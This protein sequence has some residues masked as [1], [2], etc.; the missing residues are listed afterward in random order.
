MLEDGL[1]QEGESEAPTLITFRS[2]VAGQRASRLGNCHVGSFE[3]L[4]SK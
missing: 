3:A 2:E 1:K 4:K